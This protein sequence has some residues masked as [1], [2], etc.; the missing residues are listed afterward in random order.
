[1]SAKKSTTRAARSPRASTPKSGRPWYAP[2]PRWF[3]EDRGGLGFLLMRR[4]PQRYVVREVARCLSAYQTERLARALNRGERD[5]RRVEGLQGALRLSADRSE[6][7]RLA[8]RQLV[9]AVCAAR[10]SVFGPRRTNPKLAGKQLVAAMVAA[11]RVLGDEPTFAP[12][13]EEV[14]HG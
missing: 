5:A 13:G 10:E 3:A 6:A 7:L 11:G 1:M 14:G 8:L 12:G 9:D 2:R 4:E